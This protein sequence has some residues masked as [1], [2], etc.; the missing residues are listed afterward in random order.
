MWN[1]RHE[2]DKGKHRWKCLAVESNRWKERDRERMKERERET[3]EI[4]E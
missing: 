4:V 2:S 3:E 1:G